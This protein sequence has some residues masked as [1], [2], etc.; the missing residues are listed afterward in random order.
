MVCSFHK[1]VKE[2]VAIDMLTRCSKA[3]SRTGAIVLSV[4]PSMKSLGKALPPFSLF[5]CLTS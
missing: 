5:K 3:G 2:E 4:S 1:L